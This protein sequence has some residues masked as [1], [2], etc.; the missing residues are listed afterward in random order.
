MRKHHTYQIDRVQTIS[1]LK[2]N[3]K[4]FTIL[5]YGFSNIRDTTNDTIEIFD[6]LKTNTTVIKVIYPYYSSYCICT[7]QEIDSCK[8]CVQTKHDTSLC[9]RYFMEAVKI[10]DSIRTINIEHPLNIDDLIHLQDALTTN[11]SVDKLKIYCNDIDDIGAHYIANILSKNHYLVTLH[12]HNNKIGDIGT[13]YIANS[14]KNNTT[15]KVLHMDSNYIGDI[16]IEALTKSLSNNTTL[17]ILHICDNPFLDNSIDSIAIMIEKNTSLHR[18]NMH[19]NN[20]SPSS[21]YKIMNSVL[22]N[23]TLYV[24]TIG[25]IKLEGRIEDE[26]LNDLK[27]NWSCSLSVL[28]IQTNKCANYDIMNCPNLM[29]WIVRN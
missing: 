19:E 9:F 1:K 3:D 24:L 5:H 26:I 20:I 17:E 21:V 10:N 14:L 15:L 18:I 13:Q 8:Y 11:K 25:H 4:T 29:E 22:K 2:A 7:E 23:K 16:G 12:I 27:Y 28:R 6:A